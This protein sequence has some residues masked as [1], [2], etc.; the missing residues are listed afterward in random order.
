MIILDPH[1]QINLPPEPLRHPLVD[2]PVRVDVDVGPDTAVAQQD[3]VAQEV[4][5]EDGVPQGGEEGCEGRVGGGEAGLHVRVDV[6]VGD[7][8]V[9]PGGVGGA[10]LVGEADGAVGGV[11]RVVFPAL[12]DF[13]GEGLGEE[14]GW[15]CGGCVGGGW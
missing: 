3:E 6:G 10:P 2:G 9:E 1:H 13:G 7:A 14:E 12:P 11:F 4:G 8:L 5:L 15:G